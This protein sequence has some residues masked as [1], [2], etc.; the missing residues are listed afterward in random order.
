MVRGRLAERRKTV[1]LSQEKLAESLGVDRSTVVRWERGAAMPQPWLRPRLASALQ[2]TIRELASLLEN[3]PD[4]TVAT[5]S[6]RA[7]GTPAW[8]GSGIQ[9]MLHFRI[10]DLQ[11]GG[12]FLYEDVLAYLRQAIG[13]RLFDATDADAPQLLAAAAGLT[14]MAGWM[15]YDSGLTLLASRHFNRAFEFARTSGDRHLGGHI[16]ASL[17][18][19][20][21]HDRHPEEGIRYADRGL[22]LMSRD[23]TAP[24]VRAR[25]H[26]MRARGYAALRDP[27]R[28]DASIDTAERLLSEPLHRAAS[29]WPSVFDGGSLALEKARCY[30]QLGRPTLARV[31]TASAIAARTPDRVR[32]RAFAQLTAVSAMIDQAEVDEACEAAGKVVSA[33]RSLG[34]QLVLRQLAALLPRFA[35]YAGNRDVAEF[36]DS[37]R[38]RLS[39]RH[40][41]PGQAD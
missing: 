1:G 40:R 36:L 41:A 29:P 19:L 15:A 9:T 28:C 33:T 2:L 7:A 25:L 11:L 3:A 30:R 18:H 39:E 20:A 32:S 8:D 6:S 27:A 10:A 5:A 23:D 31:A 16:L 35:P 26:A 12:Q 37:L 24:G 38:E 4:L 22:S 14:E 21:H 34:S 17:S 13:P